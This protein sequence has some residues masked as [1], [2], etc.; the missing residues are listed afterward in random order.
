MAKYYSNNAPFDI[1]NQFKLYIKNSK[2]NETL[3][4]DLMHQIY[5]VDAGGCTYSEL[6]RF[7]RVFHEIMRDTHE[8]FYG[9][10][11]HLRKYYDEYFSNKMMKKFNKKFGKLPRSKFI[12]NIETLLKEFLKNA[13]KCDWDKIRKEYI[14]YWN[15]TRTDEQIFE[16]NYMNTI[17]LEKI[18]D[19]NNKLQKRNS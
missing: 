6:I 9:I 5:G 15:V 4:D 1:L 8:Q 13:V 10:P 2:K 18:K 14:D 16:Q 3:C 7:I 11:T 17:A 12:T 19:K